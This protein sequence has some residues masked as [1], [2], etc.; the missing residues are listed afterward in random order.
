MEEVMQ[1]GKDES[2]SRTKDD[3]NVVR[4]VADERTAEHDH[5][6]PAPDW[7]EWTLEEEGYGHGV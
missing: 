4:E 3:G 6:E 2:A 7:E 5:A 1:V